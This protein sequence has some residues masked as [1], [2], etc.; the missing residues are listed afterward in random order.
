MGE[1]IGRCCWDDCITDGTRDD[2][3]EG[4]FAGRGEGEMLRR[5]SWG[6][7]E[8]PSGTVDCGSSGAW[9]SWWTGSGMGV[10]WSEEALNGGGLYSDMGSVKLR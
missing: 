5:R 10:S 3:P 2:E 1:L 6:L 7:I 8:G 4:S 9:L